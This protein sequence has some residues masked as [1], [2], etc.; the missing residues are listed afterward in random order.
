MSSYNNITCA[1]SLIGRAGFLGSLATRP[2]GSLSG[3]QPAGGWGRIPGWL[4]KGPKVSKSWCW[5]AGGQGWGPG[6][7]GADAGLLG[8]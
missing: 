5:L 3:C 6:G 1:G 8:G 7:L 4:V 2:W